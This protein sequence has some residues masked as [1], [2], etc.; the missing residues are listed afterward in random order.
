[1]CHYLVQLV[2]TAFAQVVAAAQAGGSAGGSGAATA[3]MGAASA[4]PAGSYAWL[5]LE[6]G[7]YA[8]NVV[9]GRRSGDVASEQV[10][11][12]VALAAAAVSQPGSSPKLAGT[13]LTLLGGLAGW[14]PGHAGALPGVLAAV[15]CALRAPDEKLSRNGATCVQR[16]CAEEDLCRLVCAQ[17]AGWVGSLLQLYQSKGGMPLRS[18]QPREDAPTEEL[19]LLSLCCLAGAAASAGGSD[20]H[21]IIL[22]LIGPQLAAAEGELGAALAQQRQRGQAASGGGGRREQ[23]ADVSFGPSLSFRQAAQD[24]RLGMRSGASLSGGYFFGSGMGAAAG[25]A[26]AARRSASP[27]LHGMGIGFAASAAAQQ[28]S[29][30]SPLAAHAAAAAQRLPAGLRCLHLLVALAEG[31][32][33]S[34]VRAPFAGAG[35]S[36]AAL[37]P[38]AVGGC[39]GMP[40]SPRRSGAASAN[41]RDDASMSDNSSMFGGGHEPGG[42]AP[43]GGGRT[44][45]RRGSRAAAPPS[46][47]PR[48]R[49]GRQLLLYL[50]RQAWRLVQLTLAA[51]AAEVEGSGPVL[52]AACRFLT[53]CLPPAMAAGAEELAAAGSGGTWQQHLLLAAGLGAPSHHSFSSSASG[54]THASSSA[55][56]SVFG[57]QGSTAPAALLVQLLQQLAQLPAAELQRPCSLGLIASCVAAVQQL[58]AAEPTQHGPHAGLPLLQQQQQQHQLGLFGGVPTPRSAGSAGGGS[59]AASSASWTMLDAPGSAAGGAS[60][61]VAMAA[62]GLCALMARALAG[63]TRATLDAAGRAEPGD[64]VALL[65]LAAAGLDAFPHAV[66]GQE[67]ER[68]EPLLLP[69]SRLVCSTYDPE[70]CAAALEW[71]SALACVAYT[72]D[73]RAR[74]AAQQQ[75]LAA[76]VGGS[77]AL[78]G[79]VDGAACGGAG[80]GCGH[81]SHHP[82][83]HSHAA[84]A[85]AGLRRQLEGGGG[86]HLVLCLLLAASGD[87]PP[88]S[89]LQIAASVHRVWS[90]VGTPVMAPWLEVAVLHLAPEAAPWSAN[91]Q[92]VKA[93]F[94]R[95]LLDPVCSSDMT[96]FKRVLKAFCG[97]KKK[98]G[99]K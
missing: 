72:P 8:A 74:A 79:V 39:G 46:D 35:T 98:G 68:L 15:L 21:S 83:Q 16:L 13:A 93:A 92:T 30:R 18:A 6:S 73:M 45:Q 17:H 29:S 22:Q 70:Q 40:G 85:L 48:Q 52:E 49:Q 69:F 58:Q 77:G 23:Q 60:G 64:T 55:A 53:A 44:G 63:G 42:A 96:R 32:P 82:S 9:L 50:L 57:G 28:A 76:A 38:A 54:A 59:S 27:P 43:R 56:G 24:A 41:G 7:I 67:G 86:A 97:G 14:Y 87:M 12:L 88:D 47:G 89:V 51:A 4:A 3:D 62:E 5:P 99:G 75:M 65:R 31:L 20:A 90:W 78:L 94:V 71:V 61:G 1:M 11:Q 26:E 95:Q 37:A 10:G 2:A 81:P 36:A 25:A 34:S 66:V 80:C 33:N 19:L 91:K 84:A